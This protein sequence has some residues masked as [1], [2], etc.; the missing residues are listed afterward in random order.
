MMRSLS[1]DS[2]AR[3]SC[4]GRGAHPT[5]PHATLLT[6]KSME[7]IDDLDCIYV[8][9][10]SFNVRKDIELASLYGSQTHILGL[11]LCTLGYEPLPAP[12]CQCGELNKI[13]Y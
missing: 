8:C 6:P 10:R 4:R 13:R 7:I 11:L 5:S 12:S 3:P 9:V 1:E 2:E